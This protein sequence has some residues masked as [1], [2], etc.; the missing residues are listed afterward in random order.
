MQSVITKKY[1]EHLFIKSAF[2]YLKN[3]TFNTKPNKRISTSE[4]HLKS[5]YSVGRGLSLL[6]E[7]TQKNNQ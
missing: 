4:D 2:S 5:D 1:G 7:D 3:L 6:Y